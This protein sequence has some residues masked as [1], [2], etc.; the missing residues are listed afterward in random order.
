M[1]N[2][3]YCYGCEEIISFEEIHDS[4]IED[5]DSD[6]NCPRCSSQDIE[7]FDGLLNYSEYN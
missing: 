5:C 7:F 6:C 3:Y 2:Y 1:T 4:S